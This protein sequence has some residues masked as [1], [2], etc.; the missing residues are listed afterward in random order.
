[1]FLI[2]KT[3]FDYLFSFFSIEIF[4]IGKKKVTFNISSFKFPR[5]KGANLIKKRTYQA[6]IPIPK[7]SFMLSCKGD[8]HSTKQRRTALTLLFFLFFITISDHSQQR[9]IDKCKSRSIHEY[10]SCRFLIRD[11]G[12]FS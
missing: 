10:D 12:Q 5:E 11:R 7:F 4:C 3:L 2:N 1:M 9:T 8:M 6:P